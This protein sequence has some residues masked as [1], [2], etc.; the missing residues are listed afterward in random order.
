[1]KRL[2]V[3]IGLLISVFNVQSQE[4]VDL[5]LSVNWATY[6]VGANSIEEIGETFVSGMD[7][8]A[9]CI[10]YQ[11]KQSGNPEFDVAT[12]R[13]GRGWRTPTMQEWKELIRRCKWKRSKIVLNNGSKIKG[14]IVTGQ[15][16][17]TIFLH[18][19]KLVNGL[20]YGIYYMAEADT[21]A[22]IHTYYAEN[23]F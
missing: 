18:D 9:Y 20:S 7:M 1:M 23:F 4:Y 14:Y 5:G 21:D 8:T 12:A 2:F 3:F 10:P 17:N 6:N 11:N 16:G 13:W 15:N 19:H 22:E